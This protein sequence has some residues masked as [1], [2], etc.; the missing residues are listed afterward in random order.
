MSGGWPSQAGKRAGWCG[1]EPFFLG[2][3][4]RPAV[5]R[6][7]GCLDGLR[8]AGPSLKKTAAGPN[9]EQR[10]SAGGCNRCGSR[11]ER[12]APEERQH[13]AAIWRDARR[14]QPRDRL[15]G[16]PQEREHSDA[17]G[18]TRDRVPP[19]RGSESHA[20]W[21]VTRMGRDPASRLFRDPRGSVT[22][23]KASGIEPVL[24]TPDVPNRNL[25]SENP[26][27]L[28]A[29][30]CTVSPYRPDWLKV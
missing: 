5:F 30:A 25:P 15:K 16:H 27:R 24:A 2:A 20:R 9:L 4:T 11:S 22:P 28:I 12:D 23:A 10:K 13:S 8:A 18:G 6:P 3:T 7:T 26:P 14:V 29:P 17:A 21:I 1:P 19:A